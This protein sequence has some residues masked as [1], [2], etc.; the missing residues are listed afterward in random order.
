VTVCGDQVIT[1]DD[2]ANAFFAGIERD[3]ALIENWETFSLKD[4]FSTE[5]STLPTNECP[6]TAMQICA[7]NACGTVLNA[8]A[9]FRVIPNADD[10]EQFSVEINTNIV[11]MPEKTYFLQVTSYTVVQYFSFTVFVKDCSVQTVTVKS[12]ADSDIVRELGKN[13]GLQTLFAVAETSAWFEVSD[14]R[15]ECA[16]TGYHIYHTSGEE[17][18]EANNAALWARLDGANYGEDGLVKIDT[19]ITEAEITV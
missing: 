18:T 11:Q 13:S 7:D 10:A 12:P 9:G 3:Q 5:S 17:L 4:V 8:A 16:I 14:T 6:V 1:N 2:T 15:A 19:D